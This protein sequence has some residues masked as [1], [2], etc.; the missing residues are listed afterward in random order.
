MTLVLF[1]IINIDIISSHEF[2]HNHMNKA[3]ESQY[4]AF[5][6]IKKENIEMHNQ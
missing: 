5:S 4:S 6:E 1:C 3:L 2:I